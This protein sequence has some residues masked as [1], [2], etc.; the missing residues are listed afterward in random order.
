LHRT[1]AELILARLQDDKELN[2][3]DFLE[4]F[5]AIGGGR[6]NPNMRMI[7]AWLSSNVSASQMSNYEEC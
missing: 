5:I 3:R 1:C 7:I 4:D 2:S 6:E